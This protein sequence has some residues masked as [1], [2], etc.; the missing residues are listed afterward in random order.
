MEPTTVDKSLVSPCGFYCGA[1]KSLQKGKCQGCATNENSWA[2]RCKVRKCCGENSYA[3]C[4]E[5]TEFEN[6]SRCS[7]LNS[8]FIRFFAAFVGYDRPGG[9]EEIRRLGIDEYAKMMAQQNAMWVKR[10]RTS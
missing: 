6:V 7:K 1:C 5:C 8:L 4:A 9:I 10:K 2:K 3:T